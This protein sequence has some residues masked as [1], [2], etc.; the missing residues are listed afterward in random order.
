MTAAMRIKKELKDD[1]NSSRTDILLSIIVMA[2]IYELLYKLNV[3]KKV[4]INEYLSAASFF[5]EDKQ[6]KYLNAI[7]DKL[8]KKI[9]NE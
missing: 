7:L 9:R 5:L 4:I 8:A 3:P 6:K 2:S 1:Y